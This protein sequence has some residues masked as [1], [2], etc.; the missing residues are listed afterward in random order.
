MAPDP[1]QLLKTLDASIAAAKARRASQSRGMN[2]NAMRM[3]GILFLVLGTA[4][5]L[6][7]LQYMVT[8]FA[9]S[10][11]PQPQASQQPDPAHPSAVINAKHPEAVTKN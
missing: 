8:D 7:V 4:F 10:H 6:F 3:A 2:R 11:R 9:E 5:G 1:D